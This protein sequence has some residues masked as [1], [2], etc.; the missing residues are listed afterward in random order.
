MSSV[1]EGVA[2]ALESRV[3]SN[4]FAALSGSGI[5]SKDAALEEGRQAGCLAKNLERITTFAAA[6]R[7]GGRSGGE[8]GITE[9]PTKKNKWIWT[10][11]T[12]EANTW[13][14]ISMSLEMFDPL[15]WLPVSGINRRRRYLLLSIRSARKMRTRCQGIYCR[16][17]KRRQERAACSPPV[18]APPIGDPVVERR[19]AVLCVYHLKHTMTQC[20]RQKEV[21]T[22]CLFVKLPTQALP[23][24]RRN[25]SRAA[26]SKQEHGRPV[27][28][29][30]T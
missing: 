22:P 17:D 13:F 5:V 8:S 20:H 7:G 23:R 10:S 2:H 30:R 3:V 21:Y 6:A 11:R 12:E 16:R 1:T 25:C 28:E 15:F 24:Y 19:P 14:F 4:T 26:D 29:F 27:V 9:A 18:R